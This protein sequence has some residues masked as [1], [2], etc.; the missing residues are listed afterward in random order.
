MDSFRI[1]SEEFCSDQIGWGDLRRVLPAASGPPVI[2]ELCNAI[3]DDDGGG[4]SWP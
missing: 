2:G 3:D 4:G 1:R